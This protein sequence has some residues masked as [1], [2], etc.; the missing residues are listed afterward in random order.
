MAAEQE[1]RV[2]E[3]AR[4]HQV[5]IE[6]EI[7]DEKQKAAELRNQVQIVKKSLGEQ[8]HKTDDVWKGVTQKPQEMQRTVRQFQIAEEAR[9]LAA[10]E[11]EERKT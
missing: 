1:L 4:E 5:E 10:K 9:T 11:A 8:Q 7:E 6:T 2:A 3:K